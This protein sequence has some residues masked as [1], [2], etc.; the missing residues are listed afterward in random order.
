MFDLSMDETFNCIWYFNA[1][2]HKIK[3]SV[4]KNC[5]KSNLYS[6]VFVSQGLTD[7][8]AVNSVY[9]LY[10]MCVTVSTDG[11]IKLGSVFTAA[12]VD[13]T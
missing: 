7:T 9:S 12:I 4:L 13:F 8:Q 2:S 6:K 10:E 5:S 1:L 3:I 11:Q